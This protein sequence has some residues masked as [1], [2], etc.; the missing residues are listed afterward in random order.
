MTTPAKLWWIIAFLIGTAV[1][2]ALSEYLCE[3]VGRR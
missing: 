2:I 1:M 3:Q